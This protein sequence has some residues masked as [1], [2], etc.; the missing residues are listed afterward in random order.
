MPSG[1]EAQP[2]A[3]TLILRD[4]AS[5]SGMGEGGGANERG[6]TNSRA[7]AVTGSQW[8]T[9]PEEVMPGASFQVVVHNRTTQAVTG[10]LLIDTSLFESDQPGA[11]SGRID[12]ALKPR[13]IQAITLRAKVDTG[14]TESTLSLDTGGDPLTIRVRNPT[15]PVPGGDPA[16]DPNRANEPAPD[17]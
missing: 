1:T 11:Q 2:G 15:D 6:N 12:L 16:E 10:A 7:A 13:G 17:R 4:E 5:S 8:V 9:G 3:P 14:P